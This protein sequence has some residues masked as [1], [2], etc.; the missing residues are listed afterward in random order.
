MFM[1]IY[2]HLGLIFMVNVGTYVAYMNPMG[3][4]GLYYLYNVSYGAY[5]WRGC[6]IY[7]LQICHRWMTSRLGLRSGT[8]IFGGA[9]EPHS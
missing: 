4:V 9:W 5:K 8:G 7:F 3:R 2:L 1:Y 6:A